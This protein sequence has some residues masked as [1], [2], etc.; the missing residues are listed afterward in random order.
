MRTG[1]GSFEW[2][3]E[4]SWPVPGTEYERLFL[5]AGVPSRA[6]SLIAH[7]PE[8]I[9]FV[10]YSADAQSSAP[11]LPMAVFEWAPLDNDIELAGHFRASLWVSSTSTDADVFVALRVMDGE[12]EV[13]YQTR[14]PGSRAPLTWGCLKIS[15][16]ALDA[17]RSTTERP[18]HTHRRQD[19]MPVTPGDVVKVEV[20]MMGATGRV[21]AGHRLRVEIS[22]AEGGA[23]P[24]FERDYDESYHRNAVN[25][26]FMGGVFP[27]SI[28]IPRVP[29]RPGKW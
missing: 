9:A 26:V 2:R 5:D 18:W 4:T 24:G 21:K 23:T 3:D 22:P 14:D 10:E 19:G 25:R 27:S 15:H 12:D 8:D 20:E 1:A 16:R 29:K 7:S 17:E 11:Q 13:T 28:T 6:A